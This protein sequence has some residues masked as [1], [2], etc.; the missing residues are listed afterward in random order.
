M[1]RLIAPISRPEL[2]LTDLDN[3]IP[4][5]AIFGVEQEQNWF[6]YYQKISLER[7]RQ[8][9]EEAARLANL[10]LS[11]GLEPAD[12]SEWMP[13]YESYFR[14]G[15][16]EHVNEIGGYLRGEPEFIG[17]YCAQFTPELLEELF[18]ESDNE[19]LILNFEKLTKSYGLFS[20]FRLIFL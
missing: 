6:Y 5:T 14:V 7:Q 4:P 16:M 9:W 1:A 10:A 3:S 2:T 17:P 11:Q 15:D 18:Q 20:F 8:N 19:F 12:G 13:L